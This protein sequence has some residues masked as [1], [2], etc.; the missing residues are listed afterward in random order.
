MLSTYLYVGD[1]EL[2][3]HNL[4][5]DGNCHRLSLFKRELL[6]ELLL[7]DDRSNDGLLTHCILDAWWKG[8]RVGRISGG[9]LQR[10][11]RALRASADSLGVKPGVH[12]RRIRMEE[13]R[14]LAI[15]SGH[16]Q[17]DAERSR[18]EDTPRAW[19]TVCSP[20]A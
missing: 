20:C 17:R 7:R 15:P 4:F 16:Q 13:A 8:G 11:L 12:T 3:L 19:R 9:G 6:V 10:S 1:I 14:T 5:K 2:L 18:S